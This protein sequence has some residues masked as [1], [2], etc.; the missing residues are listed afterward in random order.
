MNKKANN[1]V[2]QYANLFFNPLEYDNLPVPAGTSPLAKALTHAGG[3]AVGYGGLGALARK[4]LEDK[5]TEQAHSDTDRLKAYLA[6]KNNI[7]SLDSSTR[8]SKSEDKLQETGAEDLELTSELRKQANTADPNYIRSAID[9][10]TAAFSEGVDPLHGAGAIAALLGGAYGGYKLMDNKIDT[11]KNK[12]L[13]QEATEVENNVDKLLLEEYK[14]IRQKEASEEVATCED[15]MALGSFDKTAS[16][17]VQDNLGA[18]GTQSG[19]KDFSFTNAAVG[20]AGLYGIAA[21]ALSY[22]LSRAHSDA[23]DPNRQRMKVLQQLMDNKGRIQGTTTFTD[24]S[25]DKDLN[26]S[27]NSQPSK[28]KTSV[29][30]PRK[31]ATAASKDVPSADPTDPY[32]ALLG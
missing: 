32:A 7:L 27:Q 17:S 15:I 18:G 10:G 1:T 30:L 2:K 3:L 20:A 19:G 11:D 16:S 24:M 29:E 4:L 26:M 28:T 13:K 9:Q 12:E 5:E 14:R 23:N 25:K 6:G 8:D 21:L 31:P 22:K